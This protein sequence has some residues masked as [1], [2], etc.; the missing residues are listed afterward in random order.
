VQDG[1]V[2]D[3]GRGLLPSLGRRLLL[4]V[5]AQDLGEHAKRVLGPGGGCRDRVACLVGEAV[6]ADQ[7]GGWPRA[8]RG[9]GELG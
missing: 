7:F 1:Q 9:V 4:G 6:V 3:V 2:V 8:G 5:A